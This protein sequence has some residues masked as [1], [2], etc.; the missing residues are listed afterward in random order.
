MTTNKLFRTCTVVL[1]ATGASLAHAFDWQPDAVSAR[2]GVGK[3]ST[4]MAGVGLVWDWNFER[5]RR[6]AALTA[7]TEFMVNRWRMD[8]PGG[9]QQSITQ[10]VLLPSL[11]M[12]LSQG[13]SPWFLELGVG[14]SWMDRRLVTPQ[15]TFS[16]QWNFY[17]MLGTGYKF[18]ARGEHELGLR[19]VH[20]SNAGIRKPNPGQ[21][22]LQLRYALRF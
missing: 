9:G 7:Q 1:L 13:R 19:Y 3:D 11:R 14:A 22:L 18:G 8:A 16:T 15:R 6:H 2:L 20:V 12:H 5:L 21:D 17:D 4:A 10:L